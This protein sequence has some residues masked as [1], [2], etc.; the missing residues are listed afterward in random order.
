MDAQGIAANLDH[1]SPPEFKGL[2]AGSFA[3]PRGQKS[4]AVAIS[5][6]LNCRS[7]QADESKIFVAN[8]P[9]Y[10]AG[11]A[12]NSGVLHRYTTTH[13]SW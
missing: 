3:T 12:A 8:A 7:P 6:V 5:D 10:S 1:L 2:V 11:Q 4:K 13:C 9:L